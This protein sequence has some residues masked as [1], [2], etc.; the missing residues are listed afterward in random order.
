M[1][2]RP[3]ELGLVVVFLVLLILSLII[4][5][6]FKK[7]PEDTGP[8]VG[9]VQVWG[10][11]PQEGMENILREV[12]NKD[13][14]FLGVTYRYIE[15]QNF[16]QE[17]TNALADGTGPDAVLVSHESL[18]PLRKRIK[19]VSYESFPQRDFRDL[20]VDGAQVF[21]LSDGLYG[22]PVA[23]DPMVMYWNKNIL[24]TENIL[25][26]PASWEALINDQFGTLIERNADRTINRSVVALGEYGNV[27]NA[28]G[29]ISMLLLQSGTKG[30]ID[31]DG[32]FYNVALNQAI[33]NSGEPLSVAAEFYTRFSRP[34]NSLYSWNRSL[35][36]DRDQFLSEDLVFYFGYGSEGKELERLNPNL[37]FDIAE[38]PQGATATVRRTYGKFY[39]ISV[40]KTSDN[41]GGAALFASSFSGAERSKLIADA[42]GLVPTMRSLVAAGSN[43]TYGRVTYKSAGIAYGWL[44]PSQAASNNIFDT[45]TKDINENRKDVTSAVYDVLGRLE[46]E[47]KK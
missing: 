42:Y 14:A 11:L 6:S 44:S 46:L 9:D 21:A 43:D 2:L 22:Y 36:Q 31:T 32:K 4:L 30:V 47:Y 34:T 29:I 17:L 39:G 37:S 28:F 35:K 10:T 15:P 3:F 18:I 12:S 16:E 25:G 45:M 24:A 23:V 27:R 38:V 13:I 20:Y 1:K 7:K 8:A 5:S 33:G 19:P 40:L 26:A 41:A